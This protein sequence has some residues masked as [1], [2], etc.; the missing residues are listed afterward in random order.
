MKAITLSLGALALLAV[1]AAAQQRDNSAGRIVSQPARDVGA[2]KITIP[3]ILI[4]AS[5]APYSIAGVGNCTAIAREIAALTRELGPDYGATPAEQNR[6]EQ[7]AAAGGRAVVNSIIPF[8]GVVREISGAA[9]ADRR[10]Q[11]A[12]DAGLARRGFVR[13]LQRAK[14]CRR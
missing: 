13:G 6:A 4:R 8:R 9:A 5:E 14:G 2:E 1:P 10:L 3:P 12:V 7:L 11:A